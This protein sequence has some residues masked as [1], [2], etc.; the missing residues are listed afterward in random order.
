LSIPQPAWGFVTP[1]FLPEYSFSLFI[2]SRR[3]AS[4]LIVNFARFETQKTLLAL[5]CPP[6]L[7]PAWTPPFFSI[8]KG[9]CSGLVKG[10]VVFRTLVIIS[11]FSLRVFFSEPSTNSTPF[12]KVWHAIHFR[13]FLL[14][15]RPATFLFNNNLALGTPGPPPPP[16]FFALSLF[17]V[18]GRRSAINFEFAPTFCWVFLSQTVAFSFF[19]L[20]PS[21]PSPPPKPLPPG[22]PVIWPLPPSGKLFLPPSF[23]FRGPRWG[24]VFLLL[25]HFPGVWFFP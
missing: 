1:P 6:F 2:S 17:I 5:N 19:G 18:E 23:F 20:S 14:T 9:L 16:F 21:P 25:A 12:S 22:G 10:L 7:L 11:H 3:P 4:P 13:L 8:P 15:Q 24:G